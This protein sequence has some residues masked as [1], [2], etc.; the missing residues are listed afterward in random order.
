[1]KELKEAFVAWFRNWTREFFKPILHPI[2]FVNEIRDG[3]KEI[4]NS[5]LKKWN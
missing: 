2:V 5:I 3:F 1:M 4:V